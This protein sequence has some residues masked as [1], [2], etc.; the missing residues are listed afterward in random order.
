[1]TDLADLI[2]E[3][4]GASFGSEALCNQVLLA[5]GWQI[6]SKPERYPI[7]RW[8]APNGARY[9]CNAPRPSLD[10]QDAVD[11]VLPNGL[12]WEVS[13]T[14]AGVGFAGVKG[15]WWHAEAATPALALCIAALK[16][17]RADETD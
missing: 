16:A 5:C 10:V 12:R 13:D 2:Q 14:G 7:G 11:H 9:G 6:S 4:E 15:K 3:L 8:L 1:M 17:R